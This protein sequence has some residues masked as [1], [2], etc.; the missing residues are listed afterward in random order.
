MQFVVI[1]DFVLDTQEVH[2]RIPEF[3]KG[4]DDLHRFSPVLIINILV[5]VRV[6]EQIPE[7]LSPSHPLTTSIVPGDPDVSELSQVHPCARPRAFG[8]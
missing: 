3:L 6:A 2:C 4:L 1:D 7:L 8:F 5:G